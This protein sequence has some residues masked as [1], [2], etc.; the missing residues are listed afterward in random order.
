VLTLTNSLITGNHWYACEKFASGGY[1]ILTSGGHNVVQDDSCNP[2]A[3]DILVWGAL[4]GPLADNGG[5]TWTHSL[6]SG[7]PAIDWGNDALCPTTDQR[8]VTR[9][10]GAH[11]DTGSYEAP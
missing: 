6:L 3:S 4:I 11:C 5:P 9:P 8:G 7:S 1:V 2:S 10:Q